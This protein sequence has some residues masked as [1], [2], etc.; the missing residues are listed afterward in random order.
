[1][2]RACE[3]VG[4]PEKLADRLGVS[5]IIT[6]AWMTGSLVPPA[7]YFFRIVDILH[8]AEPASPALRGAEESSNG[9]AAAK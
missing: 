5:R 3:A 6:R 2:A 4:G 1:V 9:Q 7:S 8:E